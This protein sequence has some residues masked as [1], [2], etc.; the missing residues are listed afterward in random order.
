MRHSYS[1]SNSRAHRVAEVVI[2]DRV[3]SRETICF[4]VRNADH[5]FSDDVYLTKKQTAQMIR[6][7]A[8]LLS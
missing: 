3:D 1:N 5:T 6:Q 7:L 4:H 8:G 2:D